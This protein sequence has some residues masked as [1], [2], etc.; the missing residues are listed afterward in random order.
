L[1]QS[2]QVLIGNLGGVCPRAV[3]SVLQLVAQDCPYVYGGN[4]PCSGSGF[5]NDGLMAKAFALAGVAIPRDLAN[6]RENGDGCVGGAQP[7]DLIFPSSTHVAMYLGNG[8][9][10]ECPVAVPGAICRVAPFAAEAFNG[11]CRRYC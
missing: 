5:D 7:G 11:V 4:G 9:V 1:K 6:Q 2:P 8:L 10:A 3:E